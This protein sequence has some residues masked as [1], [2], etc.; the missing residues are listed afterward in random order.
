MNPIKPLLESGEKAS[1]TYM[2]HR[3]GTAKVSIEQLNRYLSRDGL[4]IVQ[5]SLKLD[6]CLKSLEQAE[7][8]FIEAIEMINFDETGNKIVG[9]KYK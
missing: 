9:Y 8:D 6:K 2:L 1:I 7:K 4:T 5:L 3:I